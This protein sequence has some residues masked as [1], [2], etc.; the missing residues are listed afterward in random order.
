MF[1]AG[2]KCEIFDKTQQ[3]KEK[4]KTHEKTLGKCAV[5][6]K[7]VK[8]SLQKGLELEVEKTTPRILFRIIQA[9]PNPQ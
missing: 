8:K 6:Q 4:L 1:S 2:Q 3:L 5:C 9:N 7:R